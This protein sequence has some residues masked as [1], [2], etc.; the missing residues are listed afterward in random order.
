M[1]ELQPVSARQLKSIRKLHQKKYRLQEG[2]I[3]CEGIRLFT[4]ALDSGQLISGIIVSEEFINT[5]LF[6]TVKKAAVAR[7]IH[8]TRC[9][10]KEMKQI[11]DETT[12]SGLVFTVQ[13]MAKRSEQVETGSTGSMVYLE[14]I[15]DPGN[16]GAIMRS[17]VWFGINDIILSPECVDPGNPKVIRAS[18]GAIFSASIYADTDA[19][20]VFEICRPLGY[21]FIA[22]TLHDGMA[23][24][25]WQPGQRNI[26]F[27]GSEAHGLSESVA[28]ACDQAV[29][30]PGCGGTESLN[31]AV[32][33]GIILYQL[34][35]SS[36]TGV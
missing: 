3:L 18:A 25:T 19:Q 7:N 24:D 4:A 23:L 17:C 5:P 28:G 34:K 30:I 14:N 29:T 31:L 36:R 33:A 8:L 1:S 27:F 21:R 13:F 12:P 9:T 10:S 20:R 32:A 35:T 2:L 11:S 15:S 6:E 16:L 22:T 26:I